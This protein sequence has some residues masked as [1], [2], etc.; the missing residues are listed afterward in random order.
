MSTPPTGWGGSLRTSTIPADSIATSV[1][2][3]IAI[4]TS[5]VARCVIYAVTDHRDS[6]PAGLKTFDRRCLVCRKDLG[7]DLIYTDALGDRI[8]HRLGIP[9]DHCDPDTKLMKFRDGFMGFG[10]NLVLNGESAEQSPVCDHREDSLSLGRPSRRL[11]FNF[12]W[13][14]YLVFAQQARPAD[15]D[16]F[17]VYQRFCQIGRASCR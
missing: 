1:P 16:A 3:P 15:Y 5:A 2:A 7:C 10:S 17:A 6:F 12:R 8:G 13:D 11:F 4:P 14:G 9:G